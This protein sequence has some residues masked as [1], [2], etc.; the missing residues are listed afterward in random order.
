MYTSL[1]P[2][3]PATDPLPLCQ[4]EEDAEECKVVMAFLARTSLIC[5][6]VYMGAAAVVGLSFGSSFS[7]NLANMN[8]IDLVEPWGN[9]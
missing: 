3:G 8:M 6:Q 4:Y 2:L 7:C 1:I 9:Q 5:F